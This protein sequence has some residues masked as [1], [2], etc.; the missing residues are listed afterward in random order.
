[1]TELSDLRLILDERIERLEEVA[2]R[3]DVPGGSRAL[4]RRARDKADGIRVARRLLANEDV[5]V[6]GCDCTELCSMGPTC[7]GGY[8]AGLP[9][10]GCGRVR[11]S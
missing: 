3:W 5:E 7:P 8:F 9:G 10:A 2:E 1:M 11:K 4:A 6:E